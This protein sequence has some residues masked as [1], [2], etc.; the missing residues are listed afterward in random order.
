M[1]PMTFAHLQGL[2]P[3]ILRVSTLSALFPEMH[4][5]A[6]L[7]MS[8]DARIDK[9]S[10]KKKIWLILEVI[11]KPADPPPPPSVLSGINI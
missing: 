8:Q 2:T 11:P 3:A 5:S 4:F 10:T 6:W 7:L 9:G 1:C